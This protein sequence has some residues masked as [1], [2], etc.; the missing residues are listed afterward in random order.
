MR[1][2]PYIGF[3][4]TLLQQ[5][6]RNLINNFKKIQKIWKTLQKIWANNSG[7][8]VKFRFFLRN[9]FLKIGLEKVPSPENVELIQASIE[10]QRV[11]FFGQLIWLLHNL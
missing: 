9:A 7:D 2:H 6:N 8:Y 10:L 5:R 3:A 4:T 11:Q 1:T